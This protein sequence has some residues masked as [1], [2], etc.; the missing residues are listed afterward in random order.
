MNKILLILFT[1]IV[2][3]AQITLQDILSIDSENSYKRVMIENGFST[4]EM[5]E[6]IEDLTIGYKKELTFTEIHSTFRKADSLMLNGGV[7]F[8]FS[9][10]ITNKK[11]KVYDK[12]YDEVKKSCK[13][14]KIREDSGGDL[15]YYR[16]PDIDADPRLVKLNEL[17]HN[18]IEGSDKSINLTD[19]DIGFSKVES[20]YLIELPLTL[21]SNEK[22]IDMLTKL[23]ELGLEKQK[24]KNGKN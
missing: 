14:S 6:E 1:P 5:D 8:Y 9:S 20:I 15:A 4:K 3:F 16:C 23:Y 19:I 10:D 12:I 24:N 7:R 13:F 17:I 21:I 2:C 11:N 22:M 18:N